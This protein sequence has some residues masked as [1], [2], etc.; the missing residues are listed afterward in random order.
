MVTPRTDAKTHGSGASIDGLL[1]SDQGKRAVLIDDLV[2]R[3]DSKLEAAAILVEKGIKVQDIV[4]LVDREQGGEKQL[5][6]AGYKL[7]A[8]LKMSQMLPFYDRVGRISQEVYQDS[9]QRLN[10]LNKFIGVA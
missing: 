6:E 8:A 4:V 7:H 5:A 9:V 3:A 10:A 2:T 1:N